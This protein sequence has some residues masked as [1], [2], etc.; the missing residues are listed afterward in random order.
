[1]NITI[2][3]PNSRDVVYMRQQ[4]RLE[5]DFTSVTV[6]IVP[7]RLSRNKFLDKCLHILSMWDCHFS[8]SSIITPMTRRSRTC[9]TGLFPSVRLRVRGLRWSFCLVVSTIHFVL[10]GW[11]TMRFWSHHADHTRGGRHRERERLQV[12]KKVLMNNETDQISLTYIT[13]SSSFMPY[14]WANELIST[15]CSA[16]SVSTSRVTS[17]QNPHQA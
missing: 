9:W 10:W 13:K 15:S 5:K 11:I 4:V 8:S 1:M 3:T 6:H 7:E 16:V 2:T 12:E 14:W 17:A